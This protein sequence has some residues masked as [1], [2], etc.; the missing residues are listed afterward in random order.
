M[1]HLHD[2]PLLLPWHIFHRWPPAFRAALALIL[3]QIVKCH[4]S[5]VVYCLHHHQHQADGNNQGGEQRNTKPEIVCRHSDAVTYYR[6]VGRIA[7]KR[8]E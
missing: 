4:V 5:P 7:H 6:D 2:L 1:F 3:R 8:Q